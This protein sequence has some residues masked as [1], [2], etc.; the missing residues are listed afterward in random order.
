MNEQLTRR[1]FLVRVAGCAACPLFLGNCSLADVGGAEMAANRSR[2]IAACSKHWDANKGDCSGF[3]RAV[4]KELGFTLTGQANDIFQEIQSYPWT[5][6]GVG[7]RASSIAGI[8]AS[9]GKFVVAAM[10][11]TP[12]GHVAIVVDYRNAFDSYPPSERSKAVASWG[13]LHSVGARYQ[14]I[15]SSFTAAELARTLFAYRCCF[16]NAPKNLRVLP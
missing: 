14:K 11:G 7:A 16:P 15:T 3:V 6:I 4:S 13:A 9:E 10:T 8:T 5:R 2:V 12:H 1:S